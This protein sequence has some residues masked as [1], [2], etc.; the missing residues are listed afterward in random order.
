MQDSRVKIVESAR[1]LHYLTTSALGRRRSTYLGN[2]LFMISINGVLL[3]G[4]VLREKTS[5]ST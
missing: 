2:E 3:Y 5:I 4:A 1:T